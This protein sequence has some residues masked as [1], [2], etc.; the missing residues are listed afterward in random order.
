MLPPQASEMKP[1]VPPEHDAVAPASAG[2]WAYDVL[3]RSLLGLKLAISSWNAWFTHDLTYDRVDHLFRAKHSL[4]TLEGHSYDP[5]L[6]YVP[7]YLFRLLAGKAATDANLIR[8]LRF[9]NLAILAV[10]YVCWIYVII[11]RLFRDWRSRTIA[12]V[13]L[14]VLP[15]YQKVAQLAHP[16]NLHFGLASAAFA[17]W[18]YLW[19]DRTHDPTSKQHRWQSKLV[20]LAVLIG[21]TG[22]TRPFAAVSVLVFWG[23]TM[24]LIARRWEKPRWPMLREMIMVSAIAATLSSSWFV[25]RKLETGVVGGTYNDNYIKKYAPHRA[26]VKLLPYFST[27]YF[28]ALLREPNRDVAALDEGA[29]TPFQS[30]YGNSFPTIA[31][32][33]FWGDHWCYFSGAPTSEAWSK[34]EKRWPKRVMFVLALPVSV[35]LLVRFFPSVVGTVRRARVDWRGAFPALVLIAYLLLGSILFL[36]WQA[37]AGM[38]PGKNSSIK[39]LYNA[40]LIAPLVL[41]PFLRPVSKRLF[42]P[43]LLMTALVGAASLPLVMFWP[44]W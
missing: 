29:E 35:F 40:H 2:E 21:A 8:V 42:V 3:I 23:A 11:P 32:S 39:A 16:D 18:I 4:W 30:K 10:G 26:S 14:L 41:V 27:F 25:Y 17:M 19:S 12:S 36:W 28:G 5:P 1:S 9:E 24:V 20:A 22:M 44:N 15:T 13:L 37:G 38:T 33:E 31:Y 6:Y 34:E 43:L 7:A